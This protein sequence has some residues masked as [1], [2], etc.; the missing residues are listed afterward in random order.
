MT[1]SARP[2]SNGVESLVGESERWL[3]VKDV[4]TIVGVGRDKVYDLI[5]CGELA[6]VKVGRYRR[7]PP[8]SLDEYLERLREDAA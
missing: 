4:M 6:S 3:T 2:D 7:F 5:H 8:G 1:K